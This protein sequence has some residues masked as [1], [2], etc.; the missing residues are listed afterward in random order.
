VI[1]N[2]TA[3]NVAADGG[4]R[5]VIADCRNCDF[6]K[7]YH[8]NQ[9]RFPEEQAHDAIG[10]HLS[11]N[12]EHDVAIY[13]KS[14]TTLYYAAASNAARRA[15]H[16]TDDCAK[17][18]RAN[19]ISTAPV[20]HPPRGHICEHCGGDL[21]LDD[22]VDGS[23]DP[24]ATDGGSDVCTDGTDR[25]LHVDLGT[26]L[27]GWTAPFR[28]SP[29]WR[30]VGLDIRDDLNADVVGDIRMLPFDCSP[31]LLTMSPTCRDFTRYHLPWLDEPEPDMTLVRACLD[32]VDD[33]EPD[34][35]ILENVQGLKRY[36][37]R[38]ETKRVGPYY[39]WGEFPTFDVVLS[40]G[41]KMSVSGERPE[42]R[43]KIPYPLA[44]SLRRSVEWNSRSRDT[45][46]D[47][48]DGGER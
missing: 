27:G 9:W 45:G 23:R 40:D 36:W 34:W 22:L 30:S 46:T 17:L 16:I 37:G 8:G 41:G 20:S 1:E 10:G 7:E 31:T 33:L 3:D 35:W 29:A 24:V 25:F 32:A 6:K 44:D 48:R 13:P 26:G 19:N 43:A 47:H 15:L 14:I 42:E 12:P 5:P 38:D 11:Y 21:T 28:D 18:Q 39:L 4:S 2:T